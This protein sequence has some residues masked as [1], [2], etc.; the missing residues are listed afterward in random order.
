MRRCADCGRVQRQ[1]PC[2]HCD[3][4]DGE[5]LATL[6]R[7][8]KMVK[9]DIEAREERREKVNDAAEKLRRKGV[10]LWWAGDN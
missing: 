9:A 3:E 10:R 2:E 8:E 7:L 6:K 5:I 1:E 4:M